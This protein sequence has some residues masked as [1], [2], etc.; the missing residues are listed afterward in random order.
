M[1][2]KGKLLFICVAH[3]GLY[4]IFEEGFK[5]YSGCDVHTITYGDYKYKNKKERII[6]FL[7][8]TFLNKNLKRIRGSAQNV[9]TVAPDDVFDYVFVICPEFLLPQHLQYVTSKGKKSIVYYWDGFD[10]FPQYKP[11]MKYFD[12]KYSFD[13][14]DCNKYGLNFIT[15]F[16]FYDGRNP[17][18]E[19]DLFFLGSY[20]SRFATISKIAQ[21]V[22]KQ[23]K[24]IVIKIYTDRLEKVKEP[25]PGAIELIDRFV[26]F[27]ETRELMRKS[28][29]ILDIHKDIQQ[30]LSFRVFEAMGLGKKLITT[31][32]D[33]VNYD[34]YDPQ[35]IYIWDD[36]TNE[37]PEDFLNSPYKEL[38]EDI[39]GKYS[40]ENWVKTVLG[41]TQSKFTHK[42]VIPHN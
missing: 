22:E 25:V 38:P 3:L 33:I 1:E 6:N 24:K 11:T 7:S 19:Y 26:P 18:P 23:D 20:D 2:Q 40:Q 39:Y 13:P 41:Y 29:I 16:Y 42:N 5:K 27:E 31:N 36:T 34:F 21:A 9:A 10:H 15:N 8:K 17:D 30:G 4:R 35:N 37:I 12:I 14:I 28:K 32:S